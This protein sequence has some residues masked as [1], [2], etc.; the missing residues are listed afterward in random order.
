M[1][2]LSSNVAT[3]LTLSDHTYDYE[4]S[5]K[6]SRGAENRVDRWAG[7]AEKKKTM[8]PSSNFALYYRPNNYCHRVPCLFLVPEILFL[9]A[10]GTRNR[11]QILVAVSGTRI[12]YQNL[13]PVS[14][15][16]VM[17]II[18]PSCGVIR[19]K[20]QKN[21]HWKMTLSKTSPSVSSSSTHASLMMLFHLILLCS[22]GFT[23]VYDVCVAVVVSFT[24]LSF[25]SWIFVLFYL[26]ITASSL[27]L[28]LISA[29]GHACTWLMKR[30]P[31]IHGA[32]LHTVLEIDSKV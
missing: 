26:Y 18:Q 15:Q 19:Y 4:R 27:V 30:K 31:A 16:Y 11:Y 29:A 28:R 5:G 10:T 2:L 1:T 12:W 21:T 32:D 22:S 13:V 14:G 24:S 9:A 6:L 17:G 23:P 3:E 25:I 20:M 7:V 8:G